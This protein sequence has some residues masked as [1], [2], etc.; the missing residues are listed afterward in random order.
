MELWSLCDYLDDKQSVFLISVFV[1]HTKSCCYQCAHSFLLSLDDFVAAFLLEVIDY[2]FPE[3]FGGY[4][5]SAQYGRLIF[6][7][8]NRE[9]SE[10][11]FFPTHPP[12]MVPCQLK[13][14]HLD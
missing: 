3:L 9:V 6:L 14:I 7:W 4:S 12:L 13:G 11:L 5:L 1:L 10:E 8:N 2:W